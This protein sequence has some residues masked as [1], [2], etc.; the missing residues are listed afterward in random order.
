MKRLTREER[1]RSRWLQGRP[2]LAASC[3]AI[4]T[5]LVRC[6]LSCALSAR[7]LLYRP[8]HSLRDIIL[9]SW[10]YFYICFHLSDLGVGLAWLKAS[11]SCLISTGRGRGSSRSSRLSSS[12]SSN[13]TWSPERL[14]YPRPAVV[15]THRVDRGPPEPA[16]PLQPGQGSD[17]G[18]QVAVVAVPGHGC[19]IRVLALQNCTQDT[20]RCQLAWLRNTTHACA[21]LDISLLVM[22]NNDRK[23]GCEFFCFFCSAFQILHF[24]RSQL[25]SVL[26]PQLFCVHSG[27]RCSLFTCHYL[28][29]INRPAAN[30]KTRKLTP[31]RL[32]NQKSALLS[33]Q[34]I[35]SRQCCLGNQ[36][37]VLPLGF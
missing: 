36:S 29:I 27:L 20:A 21:V 12:L 35:R 15:T 10:K 33:G 17:G 31:P 2:S 19:A 24:S 22:A 8:R 28:L 5:I 1:A 18:Q 4:S 14:E 3:L 25:F 34:P 13:S 23:A 6:C 30:V 16:R 26:C 11:M 37:E 9:Y 32:T 7:C